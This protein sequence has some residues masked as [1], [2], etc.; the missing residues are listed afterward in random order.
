MRNLALAR[1]FSDIAD[2]LEIKEESV[3]RIS[4]YR[5]AARAM[6]SLTEDVA[7]VAARG[8]LQEI[9]GI[10]KST[11]EKIEEF[12][13][14]G[15]IRYYDELR[16]SLPEGITALMSVPEVG[17]KTAVLLYERLGVKTVE[18][19]E[20]AARQGLVRTLPRMGAKTEENILKGIELIRRTKERLPLGQVLP[21]AKEIEE[22]LR[23]LK[24]VKTL[25]LA[26]SIRRMKETI[27]DIDLLVTSSQPARVME[28][29]TTLP[30]VQR[31]LA[32][33][34][35]RSSVLLEVGVQADVRV[36]KPES[37]GAAL[38]YFTGSKEHNV[39]LRERGVRR[40]YKLN[41]YGVFRLRDERR[42][43]G[44]TEE[45]VYAALD[46]PWIPPEIREDQGEVELAE[47]RRLPRLVELGDIR[48]D[49]QVHTRWSDGS[50]SAEAMARA[51]RE[52]GYEYIAITDHSRS[53][54]FAGGVTIDELREHARQVRKI[55]DRVGIAILMGTECEVHPDGSLDYPDEVL[56][57]LDIVLAAVHTRFRM[58]EAEMT[59]RIIKAMENPHVD[60]VAH[61]TGR[62]L[63]QRESY[64]V[65]VER[66]VE[67]A[68][69]TRTALE[70]NAA[71]ERLDLR[72]THARMAQ[73]RGVM[74][75]I[76]TD[77][78]TRYQLRYMEFGVGTARRG[79][80]EA[81]HVLNTL[82]LE[83]LLAYLRAR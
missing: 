68:R 13:K 55:A 78:H 20:Q 27:G 2:M 39:K 24:E 65:D 76:N 52:R 26:G 9:P 31:V 29:F 12:L 22:A 72:D 79:W 14:T 40:G 38:Q 11:A 45:E 66:L 61:P 8:A 43:A 81:R 36:V 49:L 3:F 46:L 15:H 67:A 58:S 35:T 50:D 21:H 7:E 70:I 60:L 62:L 32:R 5:R 71:P 57:E 56:R 64:S 6:E 25:S 44:R 51:A 18:E 69:R 28:V 48:G 16:A 59:S 74:L 41:E 19:L 80:V 73:E 10:G 17:P 77:A 54:K 83:E 1:I 34:S 37:F 82:P 47:K 53:L 23:A 33:G 63:G 4:A 30:A 75:A 42:V